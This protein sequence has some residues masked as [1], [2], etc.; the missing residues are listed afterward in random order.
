MWDEWF[1]IAKLDNTDFRGR[2]I[3]ENRQ[4]YQLF[5]SDYL[6]T[7]GFLTVQPKYNIRID[8][9]SQKVAT[10]LSRMGELVGAHD[11]SIQSSTSL[12][13]KFKS[14]IIRV[15]TGEGRVEI[16][17]NHPY[18]NEVCIELVNLA[19]SK[20]GGVVPLIRR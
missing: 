19:F 17:P 11:S 4:S 12:S 9:W 1:P 15:N 10:F 14:G 3:R 7:P 18:L 6:G 20:N 13:Y 8:L 2:P 5:D 16:E